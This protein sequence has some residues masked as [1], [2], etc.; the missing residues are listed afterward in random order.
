MNTRHTFNTAL[1]ALPFAISISLVSAQGFAAEETNE[2]KIAK[3]EQQVQTL[4]KQQTASL[5]DRFKFNGFMS[6]AYVSADNNSGYMGSST[7]ADFSEESKLGFQA[8]FAITDNTQAVMQLMMKGENDWDVEA[9][10]AYVSHRFDGGVQ[11]RGGKLRVPLFM[12]SDYLD[13]GY[14][15]PFARPPEEVYGSV[16]FTTYTGGDVSY[17]FEFDDSTLTV[18]AFGGESEESG[19]DIKNI[20]GANLTWTDEIWTLRAV[21]GQSTLDG[22]ISRSV[23]IPS[24]DPVTGLPISIEA[25]VPLLTLDNEKATFTG[26]GASYDNGEFLAVTEWTRAEVD[27]QYTDSDAGYITL[28]Y[29]IN[30]FT[31]YVT[32]AYY[33]SQDD[34]QRPV[35][36]QGSALIAALFNGQRTSYSGGLR[37]DALDNLAVKFDVTYATDFGDTSG[38]FQSNVLQEYD[39]VTVYTV[40]F[41]VVF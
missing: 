11:L 19:T 21:Y 20:L 2:Q 3:L 18:Q 32:A 34:D 9:E 22:T 4:Q 27:G 12:Y 28:G 14:A 5:T 39:D 10:W 41:D 37:W 15:Q 16:P 17:E 33:E 24:Q 8:T 40:K 38:G 23:T 13:V 1:K 26:V 29:R 7:S 25:S 30:A 36:S 35:F 31:P 6:G